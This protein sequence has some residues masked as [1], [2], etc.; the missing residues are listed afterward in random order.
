VIAV[1][2]MAADHFSDA[3]AD[4]LV[5]MNPTWLPAL[6]A[7]PALSVRNYGAQASYVLARPVG[8]VAEKSRCDIADRRISSNQKGRFSAIL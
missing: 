5:R 1:D 7:S 3:F 2:S 8:R 4:G 6:P